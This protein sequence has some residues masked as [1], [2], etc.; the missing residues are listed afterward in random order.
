MKY[1][2]EVEKILQSHIADKRKIELISQLNTHTTTIGKLILMT[3]EEISNLKIGQI[4]TNIGNKWKDLNDINAANENDAPENLYGC[5][6][7]YMSCDDVSGY[8]VEYLN[9]NYFT[10]IFDCDDEKIEQE[11]EKVEKDQIYQDL[12]CL[13][14]SDPDMQNECMILIS[15]NTKFIIDDIINDEDQE[16]YFVKLTKIV[17]E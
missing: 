16:C 3:D 9:E 1:R 12:M 8:K 4:I 14:E 6:K 15:N 7:V 2:E 5:R 17:K 11:L 13:I 10:E